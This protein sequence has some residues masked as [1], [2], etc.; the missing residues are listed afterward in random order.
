MH[1]REGS[2]E[3]SVS[4]AYRASQHLLRP[5]AAFLLPQADHKRHSFPGFE[6]PQADWPLSSGLH[7]N[8]TVYMAL[9]TS[10]GSLNSSLSSRQDFGVTGS[11]RGQYP[12]AKSLA[13]PAPA[14]MAHHS[15]SCCSTLVWLSTGEFQGKVLC[16]HCFAAK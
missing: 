2:S 4:A 15:R 11:V 3:A 9:A 8:L 6:S 16:C 14:T 13:R 12:K 5:C 7:H 10:H 1:G